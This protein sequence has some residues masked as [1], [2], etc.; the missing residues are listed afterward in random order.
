[1]RI[2]NGKNIIITGASGAIGSACAQQALLKGASVFLTDKIEPS[3]ELLIHERS[4]FVKSEVTD[5]SSVE[6]TFKY[7]IEKFDVID[8]VVL[9]AGIEGKIASIENLNQEDITDVLAVNLLGSLFWMQSCMTTMKHQKFGSI[10]ALSSIS[11][12]VGTP[13]LSSYVMSKHALLGLVKVA[14]LESASFGVRVNAVCPGPVESDM[15]RRIDKLCNEKNNSR[16]HGSKDAAKSIPSQ[17][18]VST[19][20]VANMVTFLCSDES[21]SCNGGSYL[22]D[23]GFTAK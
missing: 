9:C 14:A 22:I 11:G 17:R 5:K 6:K 10:V 23:G 19:N 7:A 18:Y 13:L 4:Y 12:I 20:E 3:S 15:M 21:L 1:M 16:S 2:L 8:A